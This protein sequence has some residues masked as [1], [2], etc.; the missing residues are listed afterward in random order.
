MK[1]I[2]FLALGLLVIAFYTSCKDVKKEKEVQSEEVQAASS[3]KFSLIKD[4]TQVSFTSYKTTEKTPVG[5]KFTK[6]DITSSNSGDTVF[7]VLNGTTFSIPVSSLF[8][9]DAT[10]TRDPKILQFFFGAMTNTEFITGVF[11]VSDNDTC[12]IDV[13][14]NGETSS[15]SLTPEMVSDTEYLFKGTMELENWKALNAVSSLNEACKVLHTG[16]D[17][18]TKTWSEVAVQAR[19]LLEKN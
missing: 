19:V 7:E 11:H 6:I 8:T 17:G 16:A 3:N 12:A 2:K 10:G 4:S 13:T 9:N 14:L 18:V 1:Q 5:G 15:I